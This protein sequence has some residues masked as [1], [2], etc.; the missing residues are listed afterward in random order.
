MFKLNV[1]NNKVYNNFV[2]LLSSLNFWH[3]CLCHINNWYIGIMGNINISIELLSLIHTDIC[4]F[5]RLLTFRGN[6]YII[7]FI[8]NHFKY[9]HVYLMKN[10]RDAH[11]TFKNYLFK[12]KISLVE[13]LKE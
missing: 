1:E 7:T 8:D 9:T 12:V 2:Y 3:A 4:K 6:R 5:E 10:K 11:D 13:N